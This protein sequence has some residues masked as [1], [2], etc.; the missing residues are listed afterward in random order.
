VRDSISRD[1]TLPKRGFGRPPKKADGEVTST[2]SPS[3]PPKVVRGQEGPRRP[4]ATKGDPKNL[5]LER[6]R[7]TL[8][9]RATRRLPR[10]VSSWRPRALGRLDTGG[11]RFC[12]GDSLVTGT[13]RWRAESPSA[14][15][16]RR[17]FPRHCKVLDLLILAPLGA[18]GPPRSRQGRPSP[19]G[20]LWGGPSW[21]L[22]YE[23]LNPR[24]D[25]DCASA[26][27]P[28]S[29]PSC[30]F[31]DARLLVATPPS[32][33][34]GRVGVDD[35]EPPLPGR[36]FLDRH[37]GPVTR[38]RRFSTTMGLLVPFEADLQ[39]G[40]GDSRTQT[41]SAG[42]RRVAGPR[43]L[44]RSG[45]ADGGPTSGARGGANERHYIHRPQTTD[46]SCRLQ[47]PRPRSPRRSPHGIRAGGGGRSDWGGRTLLRDRVW[48]PI[49]F[50]LERPASVAGGDDGARPGIRQPVPRSAS[51]MRSR[52]EVVQPGPGRGASSGHLLSK[53]PEAG[54][55]SLPLENGR[56]APRPHALPEWDG[57][58][59]LPP[60]QAYTPAYALR[61]RAMLR[62]AMGGWL[63]EAARQRRR[64]TR[65]V[66]PGVGP[67]TARTLLIS[68]GCSTTNTFGT[69]GPT[70][71]ATHLPPAREMLARRVC[72]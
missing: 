10:G 33:R 46:I 64:A 13:D 66:G 16:G 20:S 17:R 57:S 22:G 19:Y 50:A 27:P 68:R 44:P 8:R 34:N 5:K 63:A 60:A 62:G 37:L 29:T 15:Y 18:R 9:G 3:L 48:P 7:T 35:V 51:P 14:K 67:R 24:G 32:S 4:L 49:D 21:D 41:P 23:G 28:G 47:L 12:W 58:A 71:R 56:G 69:R 54:P 2:A 43:E 55:G 65:R 61:R 11:S 52:S 70:D 59:C 40:A 42:S 45:A 53:G 25:G 30:G 38:A 72:P 1:G 26:T 6:E 39:D 31:L 36:G